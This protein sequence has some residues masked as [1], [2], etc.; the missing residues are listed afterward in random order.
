MP[1]GTVAVA[2][3][4]DAGLSHWEMYEL[5][6][7]LAVFGIPHEDLA[8]PWYRLRL[9]AAEAPDVPGGR[10][11][12]PGDG[13]GV[14]GAGFSLRTD[15]GL[16]GLVGADTV[17]VPSVPEECVDDGREVPA[18]L[19]EALRAAAASGARMVSLCTGA[20]ALAA[21]GLLDGRRAT[22]HWQHTAELA[23]R[24]PGVT[25]DDSVLYTDDGDVLTSAGATAA[26]DLCLH[27]VRRDL[28]A[29]V[30]NQLARRLVVHAHRAGGQAQ[31]IDAP[32]PPSD[33]EGLGPVLQWATEHLARPLTVD[34]L[35]RR[36]RMSPRTF[37]RRLYEATGTTPLQWLLQQRIARAQTLL[38]CTDLPVEQVGERSGLGTAANL[39]RHFTRTV[40]VSPT[41]YRRSFPAGGLTPSGR[42]STGR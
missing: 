39:R 10:S 31:F 27:L 7:A 42:P 11:G 25:V 36:A 8:D 4:Q 2:V 37:H 23:A 41:V 29:R 35:A 19:V 24:H 38:E 28:G 15:H 5:S 21:A 16:D 12:P 32:L 33:D 6:I 40:G 20:F 14:P 30:A 22:A 3:V 9:C 34:D 13:P 17:I 18:E 26:L 1:A